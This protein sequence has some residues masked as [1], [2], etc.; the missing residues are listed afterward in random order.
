MSVVDTYL[1]ELPPSQRKELERIRTIVRKYYPEAREAISYGMPSFKFNGKYL[2]AYWGFKDHMS[3]F[4]GT[5]A[6]EVLQAKLSK[7]TTSKGTVQFTLKT[8]LPE[9]LIAEMLQLRVADIV[10]S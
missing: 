2:I 1:S 5:R 8:P 4:P 3:V 7:Y 6:V 10:K 9:S